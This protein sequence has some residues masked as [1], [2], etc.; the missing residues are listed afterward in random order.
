[1]LEVTLFY[2]SIL[3]KIEN[4]SGFA[5]IFA[6]V[7]LLPSQFFLPVLISCSNVTIV[8]SLPPERTVK[9]VTHLKSC[10]AILLNNNS[11]FLFVSFPSLY[12]KCYLDENIIVLY[13]YKIKQI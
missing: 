8:N 9:F 2:S 4:Q 11:Q 3:Q 13:F 6:I 10:I 12:I 5:V 1:M 7:L